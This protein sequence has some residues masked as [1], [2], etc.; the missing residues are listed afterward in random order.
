MFFARA[1]REREE[2]DACVIRYATFVSPVRHQLPWAINIELDR[3]RAQSHNIAK[4]LGVSHVKSRNR[5]QR[6]GPRVLMSMKTTLSYVGSSNGDGYLRGTLLSPRKINLDNLGSA[7]ATS[8][9]KTIRSWQKISVIIQ[10]SSVFIYSMYE[11]E[12][13]QTLKEMYAV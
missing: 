6:S 2:R 10:D 8:F 13:M 12:V 5:Q 11:R 3:M 4:L 7:D 9:S 1:H